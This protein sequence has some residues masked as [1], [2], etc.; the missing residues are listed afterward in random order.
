ML[1]AAL[2]RPQKV[3][4]LVGIASAPDFTRDLMWN[5]FTPA[6]K[7]TLHKKGVLEQTTGEGEMYHITRRFLEDGRRHCLLDS[8]ISVRCPVRLLHGLEDREVPWR[9]SLRLLQA[10]GSGDVALTLIKGGGHRLSRA[11]DL[12]CLQGVLTDLPAT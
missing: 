3:C 4:A 6:Q 5:A 8:E 12:R 10:L 9:T 7:E 1:L 11:Q 2:A